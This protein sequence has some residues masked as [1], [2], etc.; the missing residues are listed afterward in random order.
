MP[1]EETRQ[2]V[3]QKQGSYEYTFRYPSSGPARG[4][5]Y[6]GNKEIKHLAVAAL[7]VIG[8]GL[9]LLGFRSSIYGDY[10]TLALFIAVF[11]TSFLG[12]EIAH[13]FIAQRHGLWAEFRLVLIGAVLTLL[14]VVSPFF[15]IIAPGAVMVSGSADKKIMGKASIAGPTFNLV[16]GAAFLVAALLFASFNA[17]FAPVAYFNAWVSLFNLIP[18]AMLDGL[19][20][21]NWDKKIWTIAFATS[22]VLA[23]LSYGLF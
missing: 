21:F 17:I 11:T 15:K 10:S 3:V 2:V 6:F 5:F 1:K 9:S 16:L 22:V 4:Q 18:F 12:H 8:V 20:I 14:S 13:K 19:K 23:V 7:L